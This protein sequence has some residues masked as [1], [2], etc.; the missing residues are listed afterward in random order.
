MHDRGDG[1]EKGECGLAG[2]RADRLGEGGRGQRAGGDDH[3]RPVGGR[4]AGDLGALD[5]DAGVRVDAGGDL[6]RERLA[7]DG[8]RAAGGQGVAVGGGHD[9]AA[10]R[11]HLPVQEADGVLLMVVG[12]E[13]VGADELREAVG[14]WAKVAVRGRISCRTTGTPISAACQAASLPARPPPMTWMG[15][16]PWGRSRQAGPKRKAPGA[17]ARGSAGV[18]AFRRSAGR[19]P[20]RA[21]TDQAPGPKAESTRKPPAMVTFLKNWFISAMRAKPSMPCAGT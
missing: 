11:A 20:R 6:G 19:P 4:Q 8:E 1:V 12:A 9:E 15:S 14:R 17:G 18:G 16:M 5:G 2:E 7:V 13:G 21:S 3:A 10:G